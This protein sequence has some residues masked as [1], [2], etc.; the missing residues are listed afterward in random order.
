MSTESTKTIKGR[1][2]NKHGTEEYWILSVYT[3][4]TKTTLRE[5]PFI[6]LPG[7]LIVYDPDDVYDY[8]R[9]K[10]GDGVKNVDDL[11][12]ASTT[13]PYELGYEETGT[14]GEDG[15]YVIGYFKYLLSEDGSHYILNGYSDKINEVDLGSGYHIPLIIPSYINGIPVTEIGGFNETG[16]YPAYEGFNQLDARISCF[17]IPDTITTIHSY[18]FDS[19]D[20]DCIIN[21]I[22]IPKSV[23]HIGFAAFH[24]WS[25]SLPM[26]Y[27]EA[28]TKPDGWNAE[29]NG[30]AYNSYTGAHPVTWNASRPGVYAELQKTIDTLRGV[31]GSQLDDQYWM[32]QGIGGEISTIQSKL[33]KVE[34]T[35]DAFHDYSKGLS[36]KL[37]TDKKY[38]ICTGIGTCTDTILNIPPIYNN[39]PVKEIAQ[40]AFCSPR[41]PMNDGY[42][43]EDE[44]A[45]VNV[46]SFVTKIV[47]PESITKIGRFAFGSI[48]NGYSNEPYWNST[49]TVIQL[50]QANCIIEEHAFYGL[51]NIASITLPDNLVNIPE[52]MMNECEALSSIIIPNTVASIGAYAFNACPLTEVYYKGTQEEWTNI[53]ID[54]TESANDTLINANIHYNYVDNFIAA[55]AKY[56][57]KFDE[58][59]NTLDKTI[60]GAINEVNTVGDYLIGERTEGLAYTLSADGTYYICSGMGTSTATEII[61]SPVYNGLPVKEIGSGAF[62]TNAGKLLTKVTIPEGI[63]KIGANAFRDCAAITSI[64]LPNTLTLIGS[65]AFQKCTALIGIVIPDGVKIVEQSAFNGCTAL[66]EITIGKSVK[67]MGAY[68]LQNCTGLSHIR[69]NAVEMD[70]LSKTNRVLVSCG[71]KSDGIDFLIDRNVKSIP[72]NL[73]HPDSNT[74]NYPKPKLASVRFEDNSICKTIDEQVFAQCSDLL[75]INLP[76]GL[77][78]I[79][80]NAFEDCIGLKQVIIPDSVTTIETYAFQGCTDLEYI[81][82]PDSVTTIGESALRDCPKLKHI[83][84]PKHLTVLE[85]SLF[86]MTIPDTQPDLVITES[87]KSVIIPK[88][89]TT[90]VKE[91]FFNCVELTD[92]YYTGSKED[93]DNISIDPVGNDYLFAAKI[94]YDFANDF[95]TVG[96]QLT[97]LYESNVAQLIPVTHSQL[98]RLRDTNALIPG[99]FYRITDYICTTTQANTR[100][101]DNNFDIIVQALSSNTLS[102]NASADYHA[103]E[104]EYNFK[105]EMVASAVD[106]TFKANAVTLYYTEYVDF[107]AD[108]SGLITG[109]NHNDEWIAFDF[110]PNNEGVVVP[111]IYKTGLGE[112]GELS[113]YEGIPDIAEPYYYIGTEQIGNTTYDKWRKIEKGNYSVFNWETEAKKYIFTNRIVSPLVD[114]LISSNLAAWE[115][116]YSLDNDTSRFAWAN[117]EKGRGV[118]YYMK[119]EHNNECPYDFQNIKF[120]VDI[121]GGDTYYHYTFYDGEDLSQQRSYRA[122]SCSVFP[123]FTQ[124]EDNIRQKLNF[125][126]INTMGVEY[127]NLKIEGNCHNLN[128]GSNYNVNNVTISSGIFEKDINI[129]KSS[130]P[131]IYHNTNTREIILD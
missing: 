110:Q 56:Q 39:L 11:D 118:I 90:I 26:I 52:S 100:A 123:W 96:E 65:S 46:Q 102:E 27:C 85:K 81:S 70:N 18:A 66:T 7:E 113:G 95:I 47:L 86:E 101:A 117:A 10:F 121:G 92:I 69:F 2:S 91:V 126:V 9:F 20:Y 41:Y 79:K 37:S 55:D 51:V 89:V 49:V 6:P 131:I 87:I 77:L 88:S 73:F 108:Y 109:D 35:V 42:P 36:F 99:Q 44:D 82:I 72:A 4:L 122:Y 25:A 15:H 64:S 120:N 75:S 24:V 111:V 31:T 63:T 98:K 12:F 8:P 17:I 67:T 130:S 74:S 94:H 103:Y 106:K 16:E 58:H 57:S 115:L 80:A 38:Y 40:Y 19:N 50:P 45:P 78:A 5:N 68:A 93:W 32:L 59:L 112:N 60:V 28:K 116:K 13:P 29:W 128:V 30:T 14:L 22:Y 119:D 97:D 71:Q 1:I 48:Q 53:N 23:T 61:I 104:S 21:S 127:T 129:P 107:S 54:S 114:H 105:L 84:L 83:E 43:G 34:K 124:T 62:R 76:N 125:I 3:D 33:T